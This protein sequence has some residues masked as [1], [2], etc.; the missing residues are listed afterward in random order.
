MKKHNTKKHDIRENQEKTK[1]NVI[2][3]TIMRDRFA[4]AVLCVWRNVC[5]TDGKLV[6]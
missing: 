2:K 3:S 1:P 4:C 6:P 5:S